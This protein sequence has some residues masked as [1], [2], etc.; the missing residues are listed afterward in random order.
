M[1]IQGPSGD[2]TLWAGV[3]PSSYPTL[4]GTRQLTNGE[5]SSSGQVVLVG[6]THRSH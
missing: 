3:P 6:V 4:T 2:V 1:P 5:Q